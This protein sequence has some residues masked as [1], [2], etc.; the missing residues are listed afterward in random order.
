MDGSFRGILTL[1]RHTGLNTHT[2]PQ[3]LP[4]FLLL[5]LYPYLL[6]SLTFLS[7]TLSMLPHLLAP[8]NGIN[9]IHHVW[10]EGQRMWEVEWQGCMIHELNTVEY[11]EIE[12]EIG[13]PCSYL[14]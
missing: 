3:A 5:F 4:S 8:L 14:L 7:P 12:Q 10:Q 6:A 9:L 1:F 2:C 11:C 13:R